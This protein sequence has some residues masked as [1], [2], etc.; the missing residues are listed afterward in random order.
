MVESVYE[1]DNLLFDWMHAVV[2]V[3]VAGGIVKL[4]TTVD[5]IKSKRV[6]VVRSMSSNRIWIGLSGFKRFILVAMVIQ[7]YDI[8]LYRLKV[9]RQDKFSRSSILLCI[10]K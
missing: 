10:S 1:E 2:V 5:V 6:I 7:Y 9:W 8:L 4:C 3:V